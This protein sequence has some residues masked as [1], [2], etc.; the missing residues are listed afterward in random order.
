MRDEIEE[1]WS[2]WPR[3]GQAGKSSEMLS[4]VS[5][6]SGTTREAGFRKNDNSERICSV[7]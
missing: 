1:Q 7:A 4:C 3:E 5:I 2:D 6:T